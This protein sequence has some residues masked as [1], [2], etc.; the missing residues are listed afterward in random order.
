MLDRL[1]CRLN[2]NHFVT[3]HYFRL[4]K[5]ANRH[6]LT[7]EWRDFVKSALVETLNLLSPY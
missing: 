4:A 5:P 7:P 6:G 1:S 2:R 3:S